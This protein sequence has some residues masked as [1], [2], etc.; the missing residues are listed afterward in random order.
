MRGGCVGHPLGDVGPGH[1]AGVDHR[2][3]HDRERG[4]EAEHPEGGGRPLAVLVLEGVRR[5]VGGDDV[6][7]AVGETGPQRLGVGGSAQ[8]RVDLVDR[9]VGRGQVVG[10]EQVVGA[11]LGGDVPPR[12]L[13]LPD[14]L[15]RPGGGDVADV[16]AGAD[17]GGQQAVAGD[18][19]LLGHR[20]P[21]GQPEPARELALVHLGALGQPRLL[22]VLGDDAVERL[23]V[24]QRTAHQHRVVHALAVV[25]EHPHPSGRVGHRAE[26]GELVAGQADGDGADGVDVAVAGLAAQAPDLLD[27]PGGVGDRVGVGHRVHGGEATHRG[28]LGAGEHCLGVLAT[29][30][31]QVGVQVD[32]AG[33]RDQA[34][35]VDDLAVGLVPVAVELHA[36]VLEQEVG[37]PLAQDRGTL[38]Q[39]AGHASAPSRSVETAGADPPSSR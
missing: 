33:E 13:G 25:G 23:D 8:G 4:L 39:V 3:L 9:V 11:D 34:G 10:E 14:D 35:G 19:C 24:L 22:G 15:D 27:H 1:Q 12:R 2:L 18:H 31:A 16:E 20:R 5:V 28:G 36:T 38:D 26:L 32:Q 37:H 29:G 6:D 30:L 17:V 7:G 21:A